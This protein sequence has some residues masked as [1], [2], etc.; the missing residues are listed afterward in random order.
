MP[1]SPVLAGGK[2]TV[3]EGSGVRQIQPTTRRGQ[4]V[5]QLNGMEK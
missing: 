3:I 5:P 4:V 2:A 1:F